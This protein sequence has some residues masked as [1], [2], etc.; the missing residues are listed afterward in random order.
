VSSLHESGN[1]ASLQDGAKHDQSHEQLAP[2]DGSWQKKVHVF[3]Q[4]LLKWINAHD[5]TSWTAGNASGYKTGHE[6]GKQLGH[7]EGRKQGHDEGRQQGHD[8]GREVGLREGFDSGHEVGFEEGKLV[9]DLNPGARSTDVAPGVDINLFE[10]FDFPI[11]PELEQRIRDDIRA[12]LPDY[13][14]PTEPQWQM[15]L[16]R[17]PSTYIVAGAGSGKSTTMVL[18]LLVLRHYL[19][20]PED[21]ITVV[22]FTRDSRF[23]FISKVIK[24]FKLWEIPMDEKRGK[25]FVRTF[26]SRILDFFAWSPSLQGSKA[27]EFLSKDATA[28]DEEPENVLD[29]RLNVRQLDLMNRCYQNLFE[30]NE[31]FRNLIIELVKYSTYIGEPCCR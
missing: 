12:K 17:H 19:N 13:Q 28:E 11:S 9:L 14:Q 10:N 29:V 3:A 21:L 27:F 1:K 25:T 8:E 30:S 7:L 16:S 5:A 26:H 2:D 6:A 23:D 15:I 20:V 22:T 18:R 31:K 24:V 4:W